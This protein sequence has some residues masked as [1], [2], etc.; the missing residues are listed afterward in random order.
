MTPALHDPEGWHNYHHAFPKDY[1]ASSENNFLFYWNPTA[2]FILLMGYCGQAYNLKEG[3][4]SDDLD[5]TVSIGE[6]NYKFRFP[7][8]KAQAMLAKRR[9]SS[10]ENSSSAGKL[11]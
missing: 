7:D 10:T 8:K 6:F 2:A 9:K 4:A 5:C 3:C 1:R 11:E